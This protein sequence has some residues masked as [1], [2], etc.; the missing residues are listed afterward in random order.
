MT[1]ED[2]YGGAQKAL[3]PNI[4][5]RLDREFEDTGLDLQILVAGVDQTG[6]HLYVISNSGTSQCFD[7]LG[8][9]GIGS[10]YP[11]AMS[12]LI[13]NNYDRRLDLKRAVY[14]SL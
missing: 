5:L 4:S 14:L 6:A 2:F 7:A 3:D 10:G 9:C 13:F 11:H 12:T 8:F 1:L